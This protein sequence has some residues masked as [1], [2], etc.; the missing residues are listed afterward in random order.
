MAISYTSSLDGITPGHLQGFFVGWEHPVS[1]EDHLT[2][3]QGSSEALLAV[4]SDTGKVVGFI[5]ALSDG[6]QAGFI[7]CLEVLPEYQGQGIGTQLLRQMFARLEHL[8][9]IDL[10][11][12][13]PLQAFYEKFDMRP[14]TCMM[15]R[16][17]L[18][19]NT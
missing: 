4:D 15:Y 17:V 2:M 5:N 8:E 1:P 11:C 14:G 16:R 3:L 18:S 12:S 7:P 6:S 10:V 13:P 19:G 9:A